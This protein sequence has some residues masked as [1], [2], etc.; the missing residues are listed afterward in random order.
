MPITTHDIHEYTQ[1]L[2]AVPAM[3]AQAFLGQLNRVLPAAV[4]DDTLPVL[5]GEPPVR[6]RREELAAPATR[7]RPTA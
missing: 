4:N 2:E 1:P 5:T 3:D 7:S 6:A